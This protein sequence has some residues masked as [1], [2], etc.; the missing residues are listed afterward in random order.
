[1]LGIC[2]SVC[3]WI[4]WNRIRLIVYIYIFVY[5]F[6]FVLKRIE[7]LV[8]ISENMWDPR[9]WVIRGKGS[10]TSL[11]VWKVDYVASPNWISTLC[12]RKTMTWICLWSSEFWPWRVRNN[13]IKSFMF[14]LVKYF[15]TIYSFIFVT[16]HK[17]FVYFALQRN[18]VY[19]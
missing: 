14:G 5:F 19:L 3:T 16:N 2:L 13:H 18:F 11:P 12:G 10:L 4:E 17:Y 8:S 6:Y 9:V 15:N 7:G 1:M